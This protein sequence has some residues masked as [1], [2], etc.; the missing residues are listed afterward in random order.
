MRKILAATLVSLIACAGAKVRPT[1]E[2]DF[3]SSDVQNC[4]TRARNINTTLGAREDQPITM[5]LVMLVDKDGSVPAAWINDGKNLVGGI[6][7]GCLLDAAISSK[8]E[9]ENT[10]YVRPQPLFFSGGQGRKMQL[11]EQPPG[12]LEDSLAQS[13]LTFADWATP[14][15]RAWGAYY[16]HDNKK[17]I[18]QFK[19]ALAAKPDDARALRGLALAQLDA[20]GD[21]KEA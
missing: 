6:L 13:S 18:E 20:G 1:V 8:F 10:D 11:H 21:A 4:W 5:T 2:H 16:T 19:A 7:Q 3:P 14:V 17:A 12:K 9:S 15:D